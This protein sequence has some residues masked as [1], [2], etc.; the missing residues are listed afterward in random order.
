M[1]PLAGLTRLKNSTNRY[2]LDLQGNRLGYPSIY[3]YIPLLQAAGVNVGFENTLTD[4]KEPMVRLIYFFPRDRQPQ[5]DINA[6]ID[7]LIK[8]VQE[9]YAEQMEIHGFGRKTFSF[10]TDAH[11][12]AVVY[13]VK[14]RFLDQEYNDG[15]ASAGAEIG[16]QLGGSQINFIVIDVSDYP[17]FR[18]RGGFTSLLIGSSF[19]KA[20]TFIPAFVLNTRLAAHEL[21]HTFGLQHDFP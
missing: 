12:N 20:S 19:M 17:P 8:D 11:G 10:E 15:K 16:E 5:P 4:Q 6:K 21:G 3:R 18:Y 2:G 13:H 1:S 14:G 9:F 7:W